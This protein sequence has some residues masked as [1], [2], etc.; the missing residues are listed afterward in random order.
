MFGEL[1]A[2]ELQR[3]GYP[4]AHRVVV[5]AYMAQ[6]PGDGTDRRDRQ[7]VFAHLVGLCAVLEAGLEGARATEVIRRVIKRDD[8]PVLTRCRGPGDLTLLH[9]I[10]ASDLPDY[11]QRARDWAGAVWQSWTEHHPS[12]RRA[13]AAT[14][15]AERRH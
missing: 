2:D 14:T 1:Q 15:P 9:L 12:I 8:F 11:E 4:A 5:D 6:H 13:V 10:G 7:S 3:F